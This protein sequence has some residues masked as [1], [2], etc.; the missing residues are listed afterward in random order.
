MTKKCCQKTCCETQDC[1]T[2]TNRN[3]L[4]NPDCLRTKLANKNKCNNSSNSPIQVNSEESKYS[5]YSYNGLY[6]KGFE[7]NSSTGALV[8]TGLY[9]AFKDAVLNNNQQALNLVPMAS[10]ATA[11]QTDPL[12]SLSTMLIG[13]PQCNVYMNYPPTLS[14][15]AGGAEMV[16][17]YCQVL[18]R[19]VPFNDY[20][21]GNAIIE[22]ILVTPGYMV[23]Q[24]VLDNLPDYSP[25]GTI[26]VKTLFRG[27]GPAEH[28]GPYI[29]QLL[30]LNVPMGAG[31]LE[32]KYNCP[33][34]K[35]YCVANTLVNEWGRNRFEMIN[36]ENTTITGF[37]AV[38][39]MTPLYVH[40]GRSLAEAVHTDP[41]YQFFYQ[42]GLILAG[43]GVASNPSWPV[44]NNMTHFPCCS[45]GGSWQSVIGHVAN[46]A[47]KHAWYRK[48][49]MYRRERPEAFS[50]WI[51]NIKN[52]IV[53]N[54]NN[55]NISDV[56]LNN[57]VLDA[58]KTANSQWGS[59]DFDDS[60]LLCTSFREGSPTHPAY[61]S[62]HATIAGAC[63]T[64]LKIFFH[65]E[66]PWS[67]VN[68]NNSRINPISPA[69]YV[70]SNAT[71]SLLVE[72]TAGDKTS[73]TI[74]GEVN[75]LASNI[76]MGR[77]FAGI[78]YRTDAMQGILLGEQVA[79]RYMEDMLSAQVHN[80][81][82]GSAISISFT[83]FKGQT[84]TIKPTVCY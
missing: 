55:Y 80:N 36:M 46:E 48:W 10:G 58:I 34:T 11:K 42:A 30:Y 49:Q 12:A 5:S 13:A 71:G 52:N 25:S 26:D 31:T 37:P 44:Y 51:D 84:V 65:C 82:N 79:I 59:P 64:L 29:S 16:E 19:D 56:I 4:A 54:T 23:Q 1:N 57:S 68:L 18:A 66:Q 21:L 69:Q 33:P 28:F 40:D 6:H 35:A 77:N 9:E 7:H 60:Y 67:A 76:A 17:L 61:P 43:L 83:N 39:T 62:G 73:M 50:L 70:E 72:Y 24:N 53:A 22:D 45:G 63:C 32:Q 8:N 3:Y 75:K 38:P 15:D 14:S 41:I 47:L 27:I 2:C 81:V 78:H 74:A 20:N